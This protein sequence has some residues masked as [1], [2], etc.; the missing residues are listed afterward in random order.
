MKALLWVMLLAGPAAAQTFCDGSVKPPAAP[1]TWTKLQHVGPG[2]TPPGGAW[3]WVNL[4][5]SWCGPCTDEIPRLLKWRE[6]L[7]GKP[8]LL[9]INLESDAPAAYLAKPGSPLKASEWIPPGPERGDLLRKLGVPEDAVLP[10]QV[11]I[12]PTG[13]VRCVHV[14]AV[15]EG[16][17]AAVEAWWRAAVNPEATK[18]SAPR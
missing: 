3:T 8:R 18:A 9:F 4:W 14:G 2:Q 6:G 17:R 10:T 13:H 7:P 5:A 16:D 15:E 12:D 11:L 1:V